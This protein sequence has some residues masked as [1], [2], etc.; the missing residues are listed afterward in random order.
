MVLDQLLGYLFYKF[1]VNLKGVAALKRNEYRIKYSTSLSSDTNESNGVRL[2]VTLQSLVRI[3]GQRAHYVFMIHKMSYS[4]QQSPIV[5]NT[6]ILHARTAC[7][8]YTFSICT[9][10]E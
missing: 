3:V 10:K 8:Q 7:R 5:G 1:V 9:N 6:Y 2:V 4:V